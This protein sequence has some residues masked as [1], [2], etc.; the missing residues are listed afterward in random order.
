MPDVKDE[1]I[2]NYNGQQLTIN[3]QML[4]DLERLGTGCFGNVMLVDVVDHPEIKMAIKRMTLQPKDDS[5]NDFTADT[6]L[7]TIRAVGSQDHPYIIKFYA[8]LV[9]TRDSQLVICMEAMNASLDR[10]YRAMHIAKRFEQLD[11]LLRRVSNNPERLW[12][13]APYGIQSD[14][15]ALGISL[16]EIASGVH[17]FERLQQF[18]LITKIATWIPQIPNT[19]STEMS[20]FI[21]ILLKIDLNQRPS[22]YNEI[23]EMSV[24]KN[25]SEQPS[26]EEINFVTSI[27]EKIPPLDDY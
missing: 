26:T 17:P 21:F 8:A 19:I 16:L 4:N 9:D 10:F 24:V 25:V 2:L 7:K 3:V 22:S 15:W 23:L 20:E 14:M 5:N 1:A 6:D 11:A 18:E 27:L 13:G 12:T